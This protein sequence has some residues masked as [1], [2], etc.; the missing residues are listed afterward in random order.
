[1]FLLRS[2]ATAHCCIHE[3][4]K[5][6]RLW[7]RVADSGVCCVAQVC[8]A[9]VAR[10]RKIWLTRHGESEYNEK[11]L[12]GGDSSISPAG[13]IYARLLPDVIVDRIPLVRLSLFHMQVLF[14]CGPS[15]CFICHCCL[16]V[17]QL[18]TTLL[19]FNSGLCPPEYQVSTWCISVHCERK[20]KHTSLQ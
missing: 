19:K 2:L 8:K 7:R 11:A 1:M 18:L 14:R 20:G 15:P 13:Q 10:M 17:N 16:I 4:N 3:C 12:L 5:H 6:V 9:G